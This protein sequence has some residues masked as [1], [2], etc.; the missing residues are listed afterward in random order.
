MAA[1]DSNQE[2]EPT[3]AVTVIVDPG[4]QPISGHIVGGEPFSGWL[5]LAA[6]LQALASDDG[7]DGGSEPI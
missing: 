5:Q 1:T 3:R 2:P 7:V 4:T 6:A